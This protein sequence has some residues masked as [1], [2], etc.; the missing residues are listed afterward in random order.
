MPLSGR[1]WYGSWRSGGRRGGVRVTPSPPV[2]EGSVQ[3]RAARR[4]HAGVVRE[5]MRGGA[6]ARVQRVE[7]GRS[8]LARAVGRTLRGLAL[9]PALMREAAGHFAG[10]P[11]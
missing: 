11:A 3:E 8:A 5:R 7:G 1:S 10:L 9:R 2:M 4:R 6:A